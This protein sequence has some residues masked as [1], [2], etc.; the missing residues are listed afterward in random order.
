MLSYVPMS[1]DQLIRIAVDRPLSAEEAEAAFDSVMQGNATPVQ[2]A[3]LLVAIRTRGAVAAEVA[4]GVRALRK[5]MIP[6][7]MPDVVGMIDTCGTGGGSLTTFNI[8]TAAA[9]LVSGLGVRVAKHGNRSFSSSC[10]SADVLERLGVGLDL[11]PDRQAGV[12]NEIGVVFM[13]APNHHPAMRHVGP[14]RKEL[15]MF[16]IMNLLGPLTNPAGVKRQVVGVPDA[17]FLDLVAEALV[18]LGHEHALVVH[19]EPGVDEMS[20]LGVTHVVEVKDGR[21]R[22]FDFDPAKEL[23]WP[24]YDAA[25]LAGGNPQA[26]AELILAILKGE[27]RGAARA[28]VVLNAAAA[29]LVSGKA[30]GVAAGVRLAEQGL[31]E[32]VAL[33]QLERLKAATR[34]N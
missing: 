4:G 6:V 8:S 25:E 33:I 34:P 28:A 10:G 7:T 30:D 17:R 2:I 21:T 11:Q 16:T 32:G 31:D 24:S 26:N 13:F 19:G 15:A 29:L 18:E 9:L 14:V 20:P 5:S 12:L 27:R 3:A 22:R 1:L 23:G